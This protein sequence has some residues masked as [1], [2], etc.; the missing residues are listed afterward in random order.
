MEEPIFLEVVWW[1][2]DVSAMSIWLPSSIAPYP[3]HV[4]PAGCER[5]VGW[6]CNATMYIVN[7][8]NTWRQKIWLIFIVYTMIHA[9]LNIPANLPATMSKIEDDL[10]S[11]EGQGGARILQLASEHNI[12]LVCRFVT[13]KSLCTWHC[14]VYVPGVGDTTE[15]LTYLVT[16]SFILCLCFFL[17][18]HI[19]QPSF[20]TQQHVPGL[21]LCP[22]HFQIQRLEPNRFTLGIE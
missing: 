6:W 13:Q 19:R 20:A 5:W 4:Q 2:A 14:N 17:S 9:P 18:T 11:G 3:S 21:Q 15:I 16:N 7:R 22:F 10:N 8:K 12:A 1:K